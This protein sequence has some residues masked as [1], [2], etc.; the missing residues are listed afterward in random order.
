MALT[1]EQIETVARRAFGSKPFVT[2]YRAGHG[3]PVA[4]V[5]EAQKPGGYLG[6]PRTAELQIAD[7]SGGTMQEFERGWIIWDP[8]RGVTVL[9]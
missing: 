5:E 8:A 4:W 6:R 9:R 2:G 1:P 7:G 3:I